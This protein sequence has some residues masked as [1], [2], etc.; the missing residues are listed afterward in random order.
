MARPRPAA[1]A[2]SIACGRGNAGCR[3]DVDFLSTAVVVLVTY[4]FPFVRHS[5]VAD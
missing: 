1:A 4:I 5:T 2:E 3:S